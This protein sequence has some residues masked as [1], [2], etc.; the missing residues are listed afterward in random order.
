MRVELATTPEQLHRLAPVLCQLRLHF[1]VESL[2]QQIQQQQSEHDYQV[3]TVLDD[4]D[5][6]LCV[7]GFVIQRKLAWGKHLYVDDLVTDEAQR[8]TGAGAMMIHWLKDL[9]REQ[10]CEQLHLDSGVQRFGAHRFYLR[11][12]FD[13]NSH[14]FAIS[15]L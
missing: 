9:A 13:I 4:D 3:A 15:I 2:V 12:G 5:R 7:A 10:G 14:H 6:V 11:H 8:S 1:D